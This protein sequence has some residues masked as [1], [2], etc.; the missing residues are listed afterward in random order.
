MLADVLLS[1]ASMPPIRAT[2]ESVRARCSASIRPMCRRS[3]ATS[4]STEPPPAGA[5]GGARR[6]T[7][8]RCHACIFAAASA[9]RC[10]WPVTK[11][12]SQAAP[13]RRK[14]PCSLREKVEQRAGKRPLRQG[15]LTSAVC[16][17]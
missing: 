17:R 13:L 11:G 4:A 9:T 15:L 3:S 10:G 12:R 6:A 5:A 8:P 7:R 16:A 2:S 1:S 14:G